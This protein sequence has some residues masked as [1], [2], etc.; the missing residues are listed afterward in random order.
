M[1]THSLPWLFISV[2]LFVNPS[3][4]GYTPKIMIDA[5][6]KAY[7]VKAVGDRYDVFVRDPQA[8]SFDAYGV[9]YQKNDCVLGGPS[10]DSTGTKIAF[11]G[12]C[13]LPVDGDINKNKE[14]HFRLTVMDRKSKKNVIILDHCGDK[15]S[16]SPKGDALVYAEDYPHEQGSAVPPP[17]GY[18]GGLW[19][20]NFNIKTKKQI[21]TYKGGFND[22][23]WSEHDGNIYVLAGQQVLRYNSYKGKFETAPCKGIY[24][25][26]DG[27]YCFTSPGTAGSWI[28]RT[29]DNEEMIEWEKIISNAGK[30]KSA[31]IYYSFWSKILNAAVFEVSGEEN[32]MFEVGQGKVIAVFSGDVIGTNVGG[33]IVAVHPNVPNNLDKIEMINLLDLIQK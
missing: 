4:A 13:K 16:F 10:L 30:I 28:Y 15:F 7:A 29:S 24:F 19:L 20:Y 3:L 2:I 1:K 21:H 5:D 33:T 26:S 27:K 18:K 17:P 25:S 22:V 32:V 31:D 14:G 6:G 8:K 9:Q 12:W 23:N 11:S